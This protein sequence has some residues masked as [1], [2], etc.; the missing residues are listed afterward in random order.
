MWARALRS[1][2]TGGPMA[3]ALPLLLLHGCLKPD[4]SGS[5]SSGGTQAATPSATMS[6]TA[7]MPATAAMSAT[8]G[9]VLADPAD[10]ACPDRAA[11]VVRVVDPTHCEV[12]QSVFFGER[13]CLLSN[14]KI[15]QVTIQGKV[16]GI[17]NESISVRSVY[18]RCGIRSSDIWTAI[19]GRSLANPEDVLAAYASLRQ[20]ERLDIEL[21]RSNRPL[22]VHVTTTND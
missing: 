10:S 14:P 7:A 3:Q 15:V 21:L 18:A 8:A 13:H 12:A 20:S 16:V 17:R 22:T 4:R 1:R 5:L 9:D 11:G 19:N 6:A 2:L